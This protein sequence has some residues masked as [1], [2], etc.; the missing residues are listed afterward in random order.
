MRTRMQAS[1]FD[2]PVNI[3]DTVYTPDHVAKMVV[4]HFAPSGKCLD[5]CRGDGAFLR[6]LPAGSDWCEIAEGRDFFAY[7]ERVDW[8]IGNPPY[9]I[10]YDWLIHSFEIAD[11]IVYL[12][13]T[14]KV[15]TAY[16]TV[17]AT[18]NYGSVRE[19]VFL[20]TGRVIKFEFGYAI[21]AV[22]YQRGYKGPMTIT[23]K[24]PGETKDYDPR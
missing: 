9:S 13:P 3:K 4:G 21:G 1:L 7:H 18:L 5:P 17:R 19:I 15:F 2:F 10:F 20:G 16:R 22:Y 8:I 24:P 6:H 14:Q 12:I 11:N 23:H